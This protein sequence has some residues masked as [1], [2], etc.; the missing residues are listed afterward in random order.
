MKW[1]WKNTKKK[2]RFD[3]TEKKQINLFYEENFI[4]SLSA[5]TLTLFRTSYLVRRSFI[6]TGTMYSMSNT[7]FS[8]V[9]GYKYIF[10]WSV[11]IIILMD[12]SLSLRLNGLSMFK[13]YTHI[14]CAY[15]KRNEM[16]KWIKKKI[17]SLENLRHWHGT[18]ITRLNILSHKHS[19]ME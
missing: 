2:L 17:E 8:Q 12:F 15:I 6:G 10:K 7:M 1:M 14:V 11:I 13:V 19:E 3:S 18:G 5:L 4:N 16:R 9:F